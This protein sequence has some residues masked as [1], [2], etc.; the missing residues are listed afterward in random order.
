MITRCP[1]SN[2]SLPHPMQ[3]QSMKEA[4]IRLVGKGLLLL[5]TRHSLEPAFCLSMLCHGPLCLCSKKKISFSI[6]VNSESGIQL[7]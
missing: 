7:S 6:H 4:E 3:Q 2:Y 1:L 5:K